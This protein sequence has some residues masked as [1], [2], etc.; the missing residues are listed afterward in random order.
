V[1][2]DIGLNGHIIHALGRNENELATDGLSR[3]LDH[4]AHADVA[5]DIV[6][7]HVAGSSD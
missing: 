3:S 6:H 2:L 4:H 1:N 5:V 7:E